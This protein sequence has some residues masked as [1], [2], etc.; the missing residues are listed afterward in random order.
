MFR[1]NTW[2]KS[3]LFDPEDRGDILFQKP[4]DFQMLWHEIEYSTYVYSFILFEGSK[5]PLIDVLNISCNAMI[6]F[7]NFILFLC[8]GARGSVVVKAL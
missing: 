5:I 1:K 7:P 6:C 8:K 2:P 4:T 3:R